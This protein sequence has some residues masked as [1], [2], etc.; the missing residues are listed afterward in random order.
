MNYGLDLNKIVPV[1]RITLLEKGTYVFYVKNP[2]Y[3]LVSDMTN[4]CPLVPP[5]S[6]AVAPPPGK[7]YN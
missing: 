6:R 7:A 2:V 4:L 5:I 3:N 1:Q